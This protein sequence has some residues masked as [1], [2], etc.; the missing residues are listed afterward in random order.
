MF[1]HKIFFDEVTKL[2]INSPIKPYDAQHLNINEE[3][4]MSIILMPLDL[5]SGVVD[6][7]GE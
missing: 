6:L 3:K 4:T 7:G 5:W 2:F 1:T